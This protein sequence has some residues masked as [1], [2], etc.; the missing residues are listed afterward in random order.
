MK[1]RLDQLKG[2]TLLWIL[3]TG[4][5]FAI[6]FLLM[7]WLTSAKNNTSRENG[8]YQFIVLAVGVGFSFVIGRQSAR[9]G[10][11][12]VLRPYAKA[13]VRRLTNLAA[14]I[15]ALGATVDVESNYIQSQAEKSNGQVAI[16]QVTHAYD[17]LYMQIEAQIRTTTDA[18][19]DWREFVPEAVEAVERRGRVDND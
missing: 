14:G 15:Q 10:A 5:A 16:E 7:L 6:L 1:K 11:A 12:D 2:A 13:A 19:E 8:L 9:A 17:L 18:M 3:L 4:L